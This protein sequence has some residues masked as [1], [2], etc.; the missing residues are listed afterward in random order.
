MK[1]E[2]SLF[3][4]ILSLCDYSGVWSQPY[5][6]AGYDVRRYD[7]QHGQDIR[8]LKFPGK[9]HGILAA[10][11]CT[12]FC[13]PGARLWTEW[14]DDGLREGLS[15]V[16]ACLRMVAVCRPKWW[17]LENPPGRLD[18][19]LG[20]P[21]LSWHPWE[22]GDPWTKHTYLWGRFTPPVRTPVKPE[23]YPEDLPPGRRDRT[24]RMSSSAKNERSETPAGFARAFFL[25]NP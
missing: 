3:R 24:S 2:D 8:L 20:E 14:G 19:Y 18:D 21:A 13:R 25:S 15:V 9:V 4:T 6:D 1:E 16:D 11:P 10:P 23:E 17:A 12:K 5:V 7:L 22:Y